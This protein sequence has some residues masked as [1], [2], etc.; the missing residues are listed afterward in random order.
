VTLLAVNA[1]CLLVATPVGVVAV[2][3]EEEWNQQQVRA[4]FTSYA[5]YGF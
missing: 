2:E 4:E 3:K 5:K 1:A